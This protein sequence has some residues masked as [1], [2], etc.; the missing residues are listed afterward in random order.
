[1]ASDRS[2]Q[3][4][5]CRILRRDA[6]RGVERPQAAVFDCHMSKMKGRVCEELRF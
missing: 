3:N 4:Y 6:V 5:S 1:M 2:P